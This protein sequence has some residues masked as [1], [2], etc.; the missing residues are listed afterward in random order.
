MGGSSSSTPKP[1]K[2]ETPPPPV[3]DISAAYSSPTMSQEIARRKKRSAYVTQGQTLADSGNVLGAGATELA[4]VRSGF[5]LTEKELSKE[6][7]IKDN[8]NLKLKK[9][10]SR[11]AVA[12]NVAMRKKQ[13]Q[14]YDAYLKKLRK[15]QASN[16][17]ATKGQTI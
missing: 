14:S 12:A 11:Y 8:P 4:S 9:T 17:G 3:Q 7:F 15:E 1:P 2:I 6:E 10:S 13:Q 16:M 5:D